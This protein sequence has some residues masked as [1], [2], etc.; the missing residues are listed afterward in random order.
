MREE[1][2]KTPITNQKRDSESILV[3]CG[4]KC[5]RFAQQTSANDNKSEDHSTGEARGTG[6]LPGIPGLAC[7]GSPG[8]FVFLQLKR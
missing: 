2:E 7:G 5:C 6:S 1:D 8:G 3:S 4:L